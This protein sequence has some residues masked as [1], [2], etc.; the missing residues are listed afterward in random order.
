MLIRKLLILFGQIFA[1]L[2]LLALERSLGLPVLS[3]LIL[4]VFISQYGRSGI[5]AGAAIVAGLVYSVWYGLPLSV[6]TLLIG[7]SCCIFV[8]SSTYFAN[9]NR[10][11]LLTNLMVCLILGWLIK[12][13]INIISLT[14][15][16]LIYFF[17]VV[18]VYLISGWKLQWRMLQISRRFQT[19]KS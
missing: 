14:Y 13:D 4:L 11:L 18:G 5:M 12:L 19:T 17:A 8:Y 10:R 9:Q 1:W 3:T 7:L 2:T 15:H 16:A 6:G